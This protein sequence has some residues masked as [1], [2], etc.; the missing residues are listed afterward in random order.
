M[1]DLLFFEVI[2]FFELEIKMW[3]RVLKSRVMK[4]WVES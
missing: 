2:I 1:R 3:V 4:K